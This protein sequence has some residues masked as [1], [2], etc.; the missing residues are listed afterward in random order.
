[1]ENT[2]PPPFSYSNNWERKKIGGNDALERSAQSFLNKVLHK[3]G[4]KFEKTPIGSFTN[5]GNG[6][7]KKNMYIYIYLN[8]VNNRDVE[9]KNQW[10]SDQYEYN[11]L[12]QKD[13]I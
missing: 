10:S 13:G 12:N 2:L 6:E 4:A 11:K 5:F 7:Y 3:A 9:D 1:L 8:R